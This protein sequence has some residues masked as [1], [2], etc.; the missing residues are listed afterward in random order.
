MRK[1]SISK[2]LNE[3]FLTGEVKNDQQFEALKHAIKI[4]NASLADGPDSN[5]NSARGNFCYGKLKPAV[6]PD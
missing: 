1:T 4:V 5:L 3:V 2:S 6:P